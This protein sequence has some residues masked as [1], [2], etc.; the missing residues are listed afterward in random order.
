LACKYKELFPK[1]VFTKVTESEAKTSR[2]G[3]RI[4]TSIGGT[5]TGRGADIVIIDDPLKA[6]DA[7]SVTARTRVIDWYQGTLMSRLNNQKKGAILVVMQRLHEDDLA[8]HILRTDG[9]ETN[10]ETASSEP[11]HNTMWRHLELPAIAI[12][13]QQITLTNGRQHQRKQGDILQPR[14]INS[15]LFR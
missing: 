1:T 11:S 10:S 8:G 15:V 14:N 5:L 13:D 3:G 9:Q 12:E 2:G 7:A 4:T 6:E